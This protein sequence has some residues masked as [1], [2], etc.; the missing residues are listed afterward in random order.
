MHNSKAHLSVMLNEVLNILSPHDNVT[1]IDATFGAGGHTR[2]ILQ[3]A[4]NC[5]VIGI[6]RDPNVCRFASECTDEYNDRFQFINAK[7]SENS[8]TWYIK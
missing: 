5:K 7:F 4:S 3:Y 1:Y 6:D 8:T 2:A